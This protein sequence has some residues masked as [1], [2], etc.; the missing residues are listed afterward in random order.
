MARRKKFN[1]EVDP[2]TDTMP[3]AALT[4]RS[5]NHPWDRQKLPPSRRL[6][7]LRLGQTETVWQCLRCGSRR[8]ELFELPTFDTL[9]T[10]IEYS[11]DY[12]MSTQ[13]K[14]TGRL[15]KVEARKA[16]YMREIPEL[17]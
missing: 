17:T 10:R 14:G 5:M 9:S 6:E 4:C 11:Y 16:M 7:L 1:V 8:I 2:R 13:F 12:L 3:D 15:P